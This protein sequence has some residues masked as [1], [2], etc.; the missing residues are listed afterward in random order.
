MTA[1]YLVRGSASVVAAWSTRRLPFEPKGWLLDLRS[2]LREAIRHL[3][4]SGALHAS[5]TSPDRSFSDLENVLFYNVG[6]AAFSPLGLQTLSFERS[7][8]EVT[9]AVSLDDTVTHH[10]AYS[11]NGDPGWSRWR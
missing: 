1:P 3:S 2:D 9:P 10:Y 11:S 5:Y 4:P 7:F 6:G 8:E